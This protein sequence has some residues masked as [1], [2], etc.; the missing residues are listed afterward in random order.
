MSPHLPQAR[1]E[2]SGFTCHFG[3]TL[4]SSVVCVCD[5]VCEGVCVW[6]E[7]YML[8]REGTS[9]VG[10]SLRQFLMVANSR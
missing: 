9:D 1:Q 10:P 5:C 3:A 8:P 7:T 4:S 2:F 6:K